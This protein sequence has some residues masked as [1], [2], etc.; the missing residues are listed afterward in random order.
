MIGEKKIWTI[1]IALSLSLF[2][3]AD[4][5]YFQGVKGKDANGKEYLIFNDGRVDIGL[6]I[7]END[8]LQLVPIISKTD[9]IEKQKK[10]D[11]KIEKEKKTAAFIQN[12]AN[13]LLKLSVTIIGMAAIVL[14]VFI[15]C[16]IILVIIGI[17]TICKKS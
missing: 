8:K 14:I 13:N 16:A 4:T 10:I 9:S 1:V 2:T 17:V 15:L 3:Y 12:L 11:E 6:K 5:Y 7:D